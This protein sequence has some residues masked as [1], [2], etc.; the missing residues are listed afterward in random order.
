M[1]TKDEIKT[2]EDDIITWIFPES[3]FSGI[4]KTSIALLKETVLELYAKLEKVE[5]ELAEVKLN[6]VRWKE[7][8]SCGGEK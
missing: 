4:P 1:L 7:T 2:F 6:F 3:N 8:E 5:A